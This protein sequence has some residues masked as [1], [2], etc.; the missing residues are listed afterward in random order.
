[1]PRQFVYFLIRVLK[2]RRITGKPEQDPVLEK[3]GDTGPEKDGKEEPV[4]LSKSQLIV[5]MEKIDI[6]ANKTV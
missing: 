6:Y 2:I 4:A 5:I 1:M 3:K